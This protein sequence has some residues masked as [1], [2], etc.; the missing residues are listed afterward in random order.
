MKVNLFR[1]MVFATLAIL[2][3]PLAHAQ[4]VPVRAKIPFDFLVGERVYPAG[5][6]VVQ[7]VRN[8]SYS[9]FV[10]NEHTK[11]SAVTLSY[12]LSAPE[13]AKQTM[14]VFHRVG[15]T[16][17]LY[18]IWAGDSRVGRQVAISR[19][20]ARMAQKGTKTDTTTVAASIIH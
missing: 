14:L 1:L 5:E 20:E 12:P 2:L 19:T 4:A 9:L 18:Q 11:A 6:Y 8:D 13:P 7:P 17:F 3:G 15:N 10:R 16:Y